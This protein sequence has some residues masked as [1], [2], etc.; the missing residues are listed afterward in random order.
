[1]PFVRFNP[2][3]TGRDSAGDCTVRAIARAMDWDWEKAYAQLCLEGF[4]IGNMPSA[5]ATWISFLLNHGFVEHSL[6][7]RCKDCYT[8]EQFA[9]DHPVGTFVVGS[10]DHVVAVIGEVVNGVTPAEA[11]WYDSWNSRNINPIYYF[12]KIEGG[13]KN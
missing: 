13:D 10:G 7:S 11:K 12:E 2:N 3:P 4:I 1:M 6:F 8:L 9:R 5:N